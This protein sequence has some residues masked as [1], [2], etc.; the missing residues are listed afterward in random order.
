M[1]IPN[2][3]R[4]TPIIA[5]VVVLALASLVSAEG[6]GTCN[7][8]DKD[9]CYELMANDSLPC[10][11]LENNWFYEWTCCFPYPPVPPMYDCWCQS[12]PTTAGIV[13]VSVIM[14]FALIGAIIAGIRDY[15][16]TQKWKNRN[17]ITSQPKKSL[18]E[19][20]RKPIS[21]SK[22]E[23]VMVTTAKDAQDIGDVQVGDMSSSKIND[24]TE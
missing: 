1:K 23:N 20:L 13:T 8:Y 7:P 21:M 9:T 17:N 11:C 16:R 12:E 4:S 19:Q 10:K 5:L 3:L 2:L 24:K 22:L 6:N 15:R 18:G 14:A